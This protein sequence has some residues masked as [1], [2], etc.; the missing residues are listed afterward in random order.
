MLNVSN[1]LKNRIEI[2]HSSVDKFEKFQ[3]QMIGKTNIISTSNKTLR[4][5]KE[6]P[7]LLMYW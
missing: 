7:K 1:S 4:K 3:T 5:K 2:R 6:K